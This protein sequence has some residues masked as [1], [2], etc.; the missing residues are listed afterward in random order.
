MP[1]LSTKPD[2]SSAF[3]RAGTL[4]VVAASLSASPFVADDAHALKIFGLT[5]FGKEDPATEVI[6]PV[7]YDLTFD[8]GSA[9]GDLERELRRAS[10]LHENRDEPVSGNLGVVIRARDDRDRLIAKLYENARYGGVVS[11]LVN[12]TPLDQ[13][14]PNPDFPDGRPVP[15]SIRIEPGASFTFGQVRLLGDAAELDPDAY[16]LTLGA[17]AGSLV[18][19]RAAEHIAT[20]LKAR[21]HPLARITTREVVA[22]HPTRTVEVTISADAGPKA[23]I[24][25]VGVAGARQVNAAFIHRYSRLRNGEPYSPR[26][27]EKAAERLRRLGVFSSVTMK[28]AD[29]LSPDGTLPIEIE[30]AEGKQRYFGVGAT[31]SSIDGLGLQGY[32]GHRNL[33]GQAESLRI[34][35]TVG[36]LGDSDSLRDLD[37][38]AGI[39]FTKPGFL[40]P[41]ATLNAGIQASTQDTTS[42]DLTAITGRTSV[43]YEFTDYDTVTG[44]FELR[45]SDIDDAFG[46]NRYLTFSSPFEYVRDTR[47]NTLDPTEGYRATVSATPSYEFLGPAFFTSLEGSISAY[48]SLGSEDGVVLAGKFSL[49]SLFGGNALADIPA[50]R[51]FFA[52]GGGSVRGYAYEEISPYNATGD[53]TGGRSYAT[54]SIEARVRITDTIGIVPFLDAGTVSDSNFPDFSDVR[55]GAG[56]G[57]RYATPFGPIR[58]DV[59]APLDPYDG[60]SRYGIYVGIGQSF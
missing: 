31:V 30:V 44:G 2:F 37:Y 56:V 32:W 52:G 10:L 36:R 38:S 42:Y 59:A 3:R 20:D 58:L 49:G 43:G 5:L 1:I 35:G 7:R 48:Q 25:E 22:D 50:D 54:A 29:R 33:F 51:R 47:D 27:I 9:N 12:G 60:G 8:T 19:L 28:E 40:V 45:W 55:I 13:L 21:S 39:S 18:I 16:D 17:E 24:G 6:N 53:A 57:L 11:V 23:P 14:P 34:E 41:R 26:K 15:V 4:V 46:S